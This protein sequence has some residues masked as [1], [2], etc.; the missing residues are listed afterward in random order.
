MKALMLAKKSK[1]QREGLILLGL[2]ELFIE[3]G[4]PIGSNTLKERGFEK[5]SSATIRNYFAKLEKKGYLKQ[6]H[7]S[8]GR[9][10]T[11]LAFQFYANTYLKSPVLDEKNKKIIRKA[12][13]KETRQLGQYFQLISEV[14]SEITRCAVFLL[15]PSFD[16][17]FILDIKFVMIDQH[18]SL[19]ILITDFG[20]VH[21]E[22]LYVDKKIS[23][24]ALKRIER[25]FKWKLQNSDKPALS[26]E[27]ELIASKFYSEVML[28]Y[29]VGSTFLSESDIYKTGFSKLLSYTDFHD[30]TSLAEGLAVFENK[31]VLFKLLKECMRAGELSCWV[32]GH[33]H[34]CSAIAIP[35][36]IHQTIIGSFALLGPNRIPYKELFGVLEYASEVVKESLTKS[37]Y[38]FKI[39][40]KEPGTSPEKFLLLE[41]KT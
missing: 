36:R 4:V 7:S 30:A 34:A 19:C 3:L 38:K 5:L 33:L 1:D 25:F 41:N 18:R 31:E 26:P 37:I 35:Y 6:P 40:F 21:T 14:L 29:L 11:P 10:P 22:L 27:E 28:R 17:D 12:L 8:G 20:V 13:N 16:Q 32:G 2:V 9:L 39:T 15:A 24:F 23:S